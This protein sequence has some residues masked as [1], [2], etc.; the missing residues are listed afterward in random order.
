[1]LEQKSGQD[2]QE[3]PPG[4]RGDGFRGTVLVADDDPVIL[5]Y[6]R[7]VFQPD[8]ASE[9][10]LLG[11]VGTHKGPSLD[12]HVFSSGEDLVTWY[13]K[14]LA[15]GRTA[16]VCIL[17]MRMPGMSGMDTALKLRAMDPAMEIVLCTAYSDVGIDQIRQRLHDGFYYVRK[18]FSRGEFFLLVQSLAIGWNHKTRLAEREE[19]F[20]SVV[21]ALGDGVLLAGRDGA[22]LESNSQARHMLGLKGAAGEGEKIPEGVFVSESGEVF[23]ELQEAFRHTFQV[24]QSTRN[25]VLG[26]S[27]Q[28]RIDRWVVVNAE[29]VWGEGDLRPHAVVLSLHDITALRG[30]IEE[31]RRTNVA[32]EAARDE[33]DRNAE[34]AT[35]AR[36]AKMRFLANMSHE[37]RTPM[38]A[39][40]GLSKLLLQGPL[41]PEQERF[42]T[43]LKGSGQALLGILNDILDFSKIEAGKL[44]LETLEFDLRG[45]LEDVAETFS[46][47]ARTKGIDL[48]LSVDGDGRGTVVGDPGRV[49]Q[50]LSNLLTNA[51][52]FTERGEVSLLADL[53]DLPDGG[54]SARFSVQ[55]TGPGIEPSRLAGLFKPFVQADDTIARRFGGTG[56]GLSISRDLVER[57][58]GEISAESAPG[59]GSVFRVSLRFEAA[60]STPSQ[61]PPDEFLKG[62]RILVADAHDSS[63]EALTLLLAGF[64]C[65]VEAVPSVEILRSALSADRGWSAVFVDRSVAGDDPAAWLSLELGGLGPRPPMLL[66]TQLGV[67]GE[68]GEAARAGW[69]AYLT[70]PIRSALVRSALARC[71]NGEVPAGGVVTR[72]SLEESVGKGLRIL[73]AEDAPVNQLLVRRILEGLGQIPT[74]VSDGAEALEA[75]G[76]GSYDL[77]LMD[78]QMPGMDGFEATR[79]LRAGQVPNARPDQVVVALTAGATQE[80]RQK[81]LDC[82][83]DE[84]LLKPFSTKQIA[85]LL[86]RI[87]DGIDLGLQFGE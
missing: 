78:C 30:K 64:G 23:G 17:D 15:E 74:I 56:L 26:L 10:D 18:P 35:A 41:D 48:V 52:K 12:C 70:K 11:E 2:D 8:L 20:R 36:D 69:S 14:E 72:H 59:Q 51:I 54:V 19:R 29:A 65:E 21:R 45:L 13:F 38:T 80:E 34:A 79:R 37:I 44:S 32:L 7:K 46:I 58:G 5:D 66:L 49:R 67:R 61:E 40:L 76:T 16:P 3:L 6:Y 86:H 75:L 71:L 83:M 60:A 57:M 28:G 87:Q 63:R 85:K 84:V 53:Q 22:I 4:P 62:R 47:Q 39:I 50:I 68:A 9:F 33:A 77:V 27:L 42:A 31:L 24:G 43:L 81:C 82:G 25:L 1:M 73:V 55:D